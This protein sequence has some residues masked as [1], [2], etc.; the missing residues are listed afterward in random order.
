MMSATSDQVHTRP[1][2]KRSWVVSLLAVSFAAIAQNHNFGADAFNTR[3]NLARRPGLEYSSWET[4]R[5]LSSRQQQYPHEPQKMGTLSRQRTSFQGR[6][7]S[8]RFFA[9]S[10]GSTG[11]KSLNIDFSNDSH[12]EDELLWECIVDPMS[13][14]ECTDYVGHHKETANDGIN[15]AMKE[16][17]D[18]DKVTLQDKISMAATGTAVFASFALLIAISGPGSWRFFLAGGLCAAASHA[19]PTPLDVVKVRSW[20]IKLAV[21]MALPQVIIINVLMRD[22]TFPVH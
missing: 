16:E 19:I 10:T 20:Q 15:W 22:L 18:L 9:A 12:D 6:P 1:S 11:G 13:C 2:W 7:F 21:N 4:A 8:S 14:D 17:E 3:P 5:R